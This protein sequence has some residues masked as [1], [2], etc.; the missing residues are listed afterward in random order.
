M[1]RPVVPGVDSAFLHWPHG[2]EHLRGSA[3]PCGG[4]V[5]L[6][7]WS[8]SRGSA[9]KAMHACPGLLADCLCPAQL[10]HGLSGRTLGIA[11]SL[12]RA[13]PQGP[14]AAS[15]RLEGEC[16]NP[17]TRESSPR[18][19]NTQ[20]KGE[21]VWT[22]S[23]LWLALPHLHPCTLR[24]TWQPPPFPQLR[25]RVLLSVLSEQERPGLSLGGREGR[26]AETDLAFHTHFLT[27]S[28]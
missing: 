23:P 1:M 16:L 10:P 12:G 14:T 11:M 17:G 15:Q 22:V 5:G 19:Q 13:L 27:A 28:G 8:G 18:R 6:V 9:L 3:W 4:R 24:A 20:G 25:E 7:E 26:P 21:G 2:W